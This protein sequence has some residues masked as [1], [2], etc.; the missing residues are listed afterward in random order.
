M[1][2]M[3]N[4]Q[5]KN[6]KLRFQFLW[7]SIREVN[8]LYR[9]NI[10]CILKM[11]CLCEGS[12]TSVLKFVIISLLFLSKHDLYSNCLRCEKNHWPRLLRRKWFHWGVFFLN[13]F[14]SEAWEMSER[15]KPTPS[16]RRRRA[17][18]TNLV[19]K[20]EKSIS[21]DRKVVRERYREGAK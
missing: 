10:Y 16:S 3:L 21:C 20:S 17:T 18:N 5:V 14:C 13:S 7:F 8:M 11:F 4:L 1:I 2:K 19:R 9:S 12:I 6:S 15:N